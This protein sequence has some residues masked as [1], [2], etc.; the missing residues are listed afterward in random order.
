MI[1]LVG[2]GGIAGLAF[3][4]YESAFVR[5]FEFHRLGRDADLVL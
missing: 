2:L 1:V 5:L 4:V 3:A